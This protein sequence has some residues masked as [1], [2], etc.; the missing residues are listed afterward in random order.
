MSVRS[1]IEKYNGF[2]F[3]EFLRTVTVADV[4]RVLGKGRLERQD[5]LTLLAPVAAQRLE[6]MAQR[7]HQ[8]AVRHFG[9]TM[10]LFTPVYLGNYCENRCLYCGFSTSHAIQRNKLTLDEVEREAELIAATGLRHVLL[11]TGESRKETPPAYIAACVERMKKW[12]SSISIEVY[13]LE[14]AE[15]QMLGAAG[16]DG[17]TIYQEVYH[18]GIYDEL[19][20]EGPKRDYQYRLD[21]PERGCR[22]GFRSVNIG[23]LLGLNDWRTEAFFTGLHADYLQRAYPDVEISISPPRM[24]PQYGGFP[25]RDVIHDSDLVQYILA[26]RLFMPRAGITVSTREPQRLRDGLVRLGVTKMSAGVCTAVGGRLD[27]DAVGQFDIA[28]ER[29]VA[30]MAEMLYR[31][32]YQPVF[33]DW[34]LLVEKR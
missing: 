12:F 7:A 20:P 27:K 24:R 2:P 34:E 15:Y 25:P 30:E 13:P 3:A 5:Y 23:A 10:L 6:D 28:D 16:V 33:K 19:H 21:A 29:S 1:E 26:L 18:P 17:L 8:S 22:A 9:R 32:G 4:D 14:E 31:Q 11:L